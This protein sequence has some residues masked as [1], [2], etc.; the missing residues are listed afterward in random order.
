MIVPKDFTG[1]FAE[2]GQGV[3]GKVLTA[4]VSS[5]CRNGFDAMNPDGQNKIV[6]VQ[7][8]GGS[9]TALPIIETLLGDVPLIFLPM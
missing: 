1:V 4:L 8:S 2:A 7:G 6:K 3:N 5:R 9:L